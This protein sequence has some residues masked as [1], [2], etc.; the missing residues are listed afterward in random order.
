MAKGQQPLPEG[1]TPHSLRCTFASLLFALGE[2]S[3]YV[4][5]QMGHT[6]PGLTLALYAREMN[7]R[8]GERERLRALVTDQPEQP[9]AT[10]PSTATATGSVR[11]ISVHGPRSQPERPT[12][13]QPFK[14]SSPRRSR[15]LRVVN[16][17]LQ[18]GGVQDQPAN[19]KPP[20]AKISTSER[21]SA[22]RLA[23]KQ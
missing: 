19:K 21:S 4:M 17:N 3:T 12:A 16:E 13:S 2:P 23:E 11:I 22:Q 8:D 15:A 1:L 14:A 7:R 6:T 18:T 5:S 9:A 10:A 20:K